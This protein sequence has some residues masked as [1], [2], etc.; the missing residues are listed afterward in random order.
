MM[1]EFQHSYDNYK[2]LLATKDNEQQYGLRYYNNKIK[3]YDIIDIVKNPSKYDEN[4]Q[5]FA[6][7]YYILF[8]ESEMSS[9]ASETFGKLKS[10]RSI[11]KNYHIDLKQTRAYYYYNLLK[12]KWI[13]TLNKVQDIDFW[14]DVATVLNKSDETDLFN[15]KISFIRKANR[16]LNTFNYKIGKAAS[17]YYDA[18]EDGKY[19]DVSEEIHP[20]LDYEIILEK[21][22]DK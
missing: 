12:T 20:S 10:M 8:N 18:L 21:T 11:R 17:L 16:L 9:Y 14:K 1:H 19:N 5:A 4:Y 15:M 6:F 7:I 22:F 2:Q 13:P 3:Y